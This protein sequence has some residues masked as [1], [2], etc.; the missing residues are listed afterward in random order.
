MPTELKRIGV[1]SLLMAENVCDALAALDL[2]DPTAS[3]ALGQAVLHPFF[4]LPSI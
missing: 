3:L 1:L 4:R 2:P